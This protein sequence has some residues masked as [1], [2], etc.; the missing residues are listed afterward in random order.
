MQFDTIT[1][2]RNQSI[3]HAF[4]YWICGQ[5]SSLMENIK[6]RTEMDLEGDRERHD[7]AQGIEIPNYNLNISLFF[8]V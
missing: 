3:L 8:C 1:A 5:Y 6:N 4:L 2:F 7:K